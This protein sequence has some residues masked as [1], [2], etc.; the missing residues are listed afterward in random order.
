MSSKIETEIK[1][2]KGLISIV[3]TGYQQEDLENLKKVLENFKRD[4]KKKDSCHWR[5]K[6]LPGTDENTVRERRLQGF[7]GGKWWNGAKSH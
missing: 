7:I 2:I 4:F 1:K 3:K 6:R 5:C